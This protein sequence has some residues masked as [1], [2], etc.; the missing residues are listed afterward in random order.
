MAGNYGA[1]VDL[2]LAST[3][4]QH[5]SWL[6]DYGYRVDIS[7]ADM[8]SVSNQRRPSRFLSQAHTMVVQPRRR[9]HCNS[10]RYGIV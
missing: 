8:A 5:N 1:G 3:H 2:I 4:G 6:Y 9:H 10:F 7:D